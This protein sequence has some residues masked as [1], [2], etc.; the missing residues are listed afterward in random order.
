LDD[1]AIEIEKAVAQTYEAEAVASGIEADFIE[2]KRFD[3]GVAIVAVV[4]PLLTATLAFI[5][6][7]V[8]A[9]IES[10]KHVVV[11]VKDVEIRGLDAGSVTR[12]LREALEA[13]K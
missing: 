11:K 1:I 13:K 3:G 7:L 12:L 6:R 9:Q 10:K 5:T 8:L 4:L 2:V